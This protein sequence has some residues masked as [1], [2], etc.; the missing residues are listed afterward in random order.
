MPAFQPAEAAASRP[1]GPAAAETLPPTLKWPDSRLFMPCAF[2]M[3]ITRS[4]LWPPIW[5][6][7]E[8]PETENGAGA[9]QPFEVRHV[10][11]PVPCSPPTIN[12]PLIR[13]G[14][15]AT[16]LAPSRTLF[17]TLLSGA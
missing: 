6:P 10:A 16:H 13:P 12:A 8:I 17:G 7:H 14:T 2:M 9:L 15:T 3:N 1:T 11:T 5:G 4:V